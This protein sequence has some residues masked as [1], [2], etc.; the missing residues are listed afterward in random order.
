MALIVARKV[1]AAGAAAISADQVRVLLRRLQAEIATAAQGKELRK[2]ARMAL[3]D[4]VEPTELCDKEK[5]PEL[6]LHDA[7][8][9]GVYLASPRG[10]EPL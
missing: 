1:L 3:R 6:V 9:T 8:S 2:Q 10:F 4:V 7:V 5:T